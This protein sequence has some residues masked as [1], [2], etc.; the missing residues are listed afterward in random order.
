MCKKLPFMFN[1]KKAEDPQLPS[2]ATI[3]AAG[4][5][6]D[7]NLNSEN[8]LRIDGKV[9]GNV[10]CSNKVIVGALG[11]VQGDIETL[12]ADVL[13]T[14][15][16][17]LQATESVFLRGK[18]VVNGNLRTRS[19]Q[20]EPD[21]CFNGTCQMGEVEGPVIQDPFRLSHHQPPAE[22]ALAN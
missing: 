2:V 11:V 18:A 13:G 14:L 6:L 19:L 7:G 3:I 8:D 21:V 12:H 1:S 20:I 15:H 9:L 4:T 16:G 17:N 5:V 10:Y 22:L